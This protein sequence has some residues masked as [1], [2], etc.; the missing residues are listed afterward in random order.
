MVATVDVK[1]RVNNSGLNEVKKACKVL[2]KKL[3]VG[4]F[5]NPFVVEKAS[6]NEFGS[7]EKDIPTR[8]F[9]QRAVDFYGKDTLE[10]A[11]NSLGFGDF[12][13]KNAKDTM[14]TLGK[15]FKHAIQE[16]IETASEWSI[17]SHNSPSTIE[18][19]GF[20]R[21]LIYTGEMHDSVEIRE[22]K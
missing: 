8:P 17:Y 10:Y 3:Q 9:M 15:G 20:D 13:V 1:F 7:Y 21:P 18:F 2:D 14:E 5:S 12:D 4:Y 16:S 11:A 6:D 19:K 22:A